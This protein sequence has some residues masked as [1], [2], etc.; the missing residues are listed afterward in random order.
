M[1]CVWCGVCGFQQNYFS[2]KKIKQIEIYILKNWAPKNVLPTLKLDCKECTQCACTVS[3]D[4]LFPT[5]NELKKLTTK[6]DQN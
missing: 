2:K 6:T 1:V 5:T 3:D 4:N